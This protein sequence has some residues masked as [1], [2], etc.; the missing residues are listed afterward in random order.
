MVWYCVV[1]CTTPSLR[2]HED[3]DSTQTESDTEPVL[4]RNVAFDSNVVQEQENMPVSWC[5]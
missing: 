4:H 3:V 5:Y 1:Q 2:L